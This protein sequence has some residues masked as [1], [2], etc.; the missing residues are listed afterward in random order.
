MFDIRVSFEGTDK[1]VAQLLGELSTD[2]ERKAEQA[3]DQASSAVFNLIRQGFLAERDPYGTA[4]V[5]SEAAKKRRA[6]GGTGTLFDTGNLFHSLQLTRNGQL[7]REIGT[8]VEYAEYF[9]EGLGQ[10]QRVI[11]AITPEHEELTAE[12]FTMRMFEAFK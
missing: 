8:D 4:W 10:V 12:I 11:L 9:Q 6:K 2:N 3:L 7:N 5:Q 1:L